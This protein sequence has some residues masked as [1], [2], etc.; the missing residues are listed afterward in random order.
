ME[1]LAASYLFKTT[2]LKV[3]SAHGS[4]IVLGLNCNTVKGDG[5]TC[6]WAVK[7]ED[8]STWYMTLSSVKSRQDQISSVQ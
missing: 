2:V 4:S 6:L 8:E 3:F 5:D 7:Y 1:I